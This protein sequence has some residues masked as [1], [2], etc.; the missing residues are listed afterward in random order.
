M[1]TTL[2]K[3]V[4][5][6]SLLGTFQ[7]LIDYHH[8]KCS[9]PSA[10]LNTYNRRLLQFH[11]IINMYILIGGFLFNPLYHLI[12]IVLTMIHWLTNNNKC[13]LTEI[14]NDICGWPEDKKLYDFIEMSGINKLVPNTDWYVILSLAIYDIY[15]IYE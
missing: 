1:F 12:F 4:L 2:Q 11:H 8:N 6:I 10:T 9:L 7:Y 15:K 14:V 13:F 3:K 5:G